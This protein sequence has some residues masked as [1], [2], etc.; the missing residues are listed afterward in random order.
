MLVKLMLPGENPK[1]IT[2]EQHGQLK[3][4][5][6]CTHIGTRTIFNK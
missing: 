6:V 5:S 1:E 2:P 3:N 4:V